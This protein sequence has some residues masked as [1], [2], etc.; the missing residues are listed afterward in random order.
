MLKQTW[1]VFSDIKALQKSNGRGKMTYFVCFPRL[2][3]S[4]SFLRITCTTGA[5]ESV[6]I[7]ERTPNCR[8]VPTHHR[9][10][11]PLHI[12]RGCKQDPHFGKH[13]LKV[14]KPFL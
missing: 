8:L 2:L 11:H 6:N 9:L 7:G 14:L 12:R 13:K 5:Q 10:P 4:L 1:Y 3:L